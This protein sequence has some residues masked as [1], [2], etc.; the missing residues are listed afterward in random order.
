MNRVKPVFWL[1]FA[2]FFP[3]FSLGADSPIT[4]RSTDP[5]VPARL[6]FVKSIDVEGY[7]QRINDDTAAQSFRIRTRNLD[8]DVDAFVG[9][10]TGVHHFNRDLRIREL[11]KLAT[12]A[13]LWNWG[14]DLGIKRGRHLWEIDLMGA[15][16]GPALAPALGLAGEH[17]ITRRLTLY[18]RGEVNFFSDD[19]V[20]EADFGAYHMWGTFGLTA[21]YRFFASKHMSRNGPHVGIRLYFES[22]KIPFLFPSIG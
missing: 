4:S 8:P 1:A 19:P 21:G 17:Q 13:I 7:I 11:D 18:H 16:L 15:I 9:L 2:V 22:P 14:I 3:A 5:E 10:M 20:A 12:S 6:D